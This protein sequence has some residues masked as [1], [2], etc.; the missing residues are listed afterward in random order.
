MKKFRVVVATFNWFVALICGWL[1]VLWYLS[2]EETNLFQAAADHRLLGLSVFIIGLTAVLLN[3]AW[4]VVRHVY[5]GGPQMHVPVAGQDSDVLIAVSA[6]EKALTKALVAE[7]E[8]HDAEV[9]LTFDPGERRITRVAARGTI[10]DGPDALQTQLKMR[11]LLEK[12]LS[13][14]IQPEKMPDFD[15]KVDGLRFADAGK[16]PRVMTR[17]DQVSES[18]R[19]PQYPVQR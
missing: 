14:I 3:T 16:R 11:H 6:V 13:E 4:L 2:G 17:R 7:P 1:G 9:E 12:R 15:V 19:G 10:W 8:V 5:G 18:F